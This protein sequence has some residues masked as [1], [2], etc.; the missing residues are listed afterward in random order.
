MIFK[1]LLTWQ[2]FLESWFTQQEES[3]KVTLV[4]KHDEVLIENS[5]KFK[6]LDGKDNFCE[7]IWWFN[8]QIDTILGICQNEQLLFLKIPLLLM[9]Q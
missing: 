6:N 2:K 3:R 1:F 4:A 7:N 8:L 9:Q 5:F